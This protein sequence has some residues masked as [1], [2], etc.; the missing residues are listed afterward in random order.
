VEEIKLKW[1][2]QRRLELKRL[3]AGAGLLAQFANILDMKVVLVVGATGQQGNAVIR[4]LIESE[5]YLCLALIR[6]L[7]SQGP[8]AKILQKY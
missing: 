4:A 3:G 6:N 8:T 1:F 7:D 5:N 2:I